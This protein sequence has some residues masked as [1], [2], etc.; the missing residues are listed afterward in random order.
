MTQVR[1]DTHDILNQSPPYEGV[2]LFVSDRA[3]RDAVEANGA[4]AE[5]AALSE[6]GRRWG[7]AAMFDAAR[8]A[9]EVTPK[10]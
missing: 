10:L 4:G 6:F 1:R 9:N 8:V 5:A 2:D 7:T 3:L